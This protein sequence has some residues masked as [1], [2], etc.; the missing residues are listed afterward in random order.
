[1]GIRT[2]RQF[3]AS[4]QDGRAVYMD[5]E[6]IRDVTSDS[7]LAGAARTLAEL[8]DLQSDRALAPALTYASPTTGEPVAMSYIEPRSIED[9]QRRG[10]AFQIVANACQ[11]LFGRTP[12]FMNAGLASLASAAEILNVEGG[13]AGGANVRK[14][15]ESVRDSDLTLTH[16]QINPQVDRTKQT[17]RQVHDLALKVVRETDAGCYLNGMRLVGTLAQFSNEIL[18]MPSVVVTSEADAADYAFACSVPV[19]T[20][21]VKII[22]RP[23]LIPQNPGHFL[24]NPLASRFDEGDA[25]IV[26][27]NVFVPWERLY[28]YRDVERCNSL[29]KRCY[30]AEHYTHQTQT[31]ALA[32]AEFMAGLAAY[33][34]KS[35]KVDAFLNVQGQLAE[36]LMFVENQRALLAQALATATRTP[37]GTFAPNRW[38]LHTAQIF[39]YERYGR[40][41]D[42]VRS[43]A[44]GGLVA[45]PSYAE[46]HGEIGEVVQQYFKTATLDSDRRIRLLRLAWDAAIST[47]SG[48]QALYERFYQGDPVRR[49]ASYYLDYPLQP[50][51]ERIDGVLDDLAAR[52]RTNPI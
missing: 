9:L 4:I 24:D 11:G 40:M 37:F 23:T 17:S 31:R 35:T 41:I 12:D 33:I 10:K 29:Y 46:L 5:G 47:F 36:L 19:A 43:L 39:F 20:P 52:S 14:Y 26:F 32:K 51:L 49:A 27:D 2:G 30:I 50:L 3:L 48:R 42:T 38:P 22:S 13:L 34:A 1:M 21:G 18:V 7:R 8:Y 44:A 6:R 15:Y 28:I 16:I 25:T 45:A